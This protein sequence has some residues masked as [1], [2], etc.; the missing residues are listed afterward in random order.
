MKTA[1]TKMLISC[2]VYYVLHATVDTSKVFH[3]RLL[4]ETAAAIICLNIG[5]GVQA[6]GSH[7]I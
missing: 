4:A 6:L 1:I 3:L 5:S 2:D 7:F